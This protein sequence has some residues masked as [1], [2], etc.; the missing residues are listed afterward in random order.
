[1]KSALLF[2]CVVMLCCLSWVESKRVKK[3]VTK[4]EEPF[5]RVLRPKCTQGI[6]KCPVVVEP[7][8]STPTT[9][10]QVVQ[11][12]TKLNRSAKNVTD[13]KNTSVHLNMTQSNISLA[14]KSTA[15]SYEARI[16]NIFQ[17]Y[18]PEWVALVPGLLQKYTGHE[19]EHIAALVAKYGPEPVPTASSIS[20]PTQKPQ[21]NTKR[22]NVPT[23]PSR[24]KRVRNL[25]P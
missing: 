4:K 12:P 6:G 3:I 25:A 23:I 21:N 2:A 24:Q 8:F 20:V 19:E 17:K 15:L 18:N 16:I 5:V 14:N 22:E 11:P 7:D 1:M 13:S 10:N 9:T